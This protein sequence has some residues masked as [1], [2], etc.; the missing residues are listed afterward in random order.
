MKEW[1]ESGVGTDQEKH[2]VT[3]HAG[4]SFSNTEIVQTKNFSSVGDAMRGISKTYHCPAD[5]NACGV[6]SGNW[7]DKLKAL[8]GVTA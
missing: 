7:Q 8:T 2:V 4:W 6:D 3:L 1:K 5:D